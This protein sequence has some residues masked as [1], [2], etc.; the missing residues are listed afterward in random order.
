[1]PLLIKGLVAVPCVRLFS[2]ELLPATVGSAGIKT[3]YCFLSEGLPLASV[4]SRDGGSA[5]GGSGT[6]EDMF[7][8]LQDGAHS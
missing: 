3:Q 5:F 4:D 2:K 7:T 1:M 6:W 8:I